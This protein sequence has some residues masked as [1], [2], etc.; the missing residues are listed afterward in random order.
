M[1]TAE[2]QYLLLEQNIF[3][4]ASR[5]P[6]CASLNQE[7]R[8]S[9][10]TL[11]TS[12]N[13]LCLLTEGTPRGTPLPAFPGNCMG[14]TK[15][16]LPGD[17]KWFVFYPRPKEWI[18]GSHAWPAGNNP[19]QMKNPADEVVSLPDFIHTQFQDFRPRCPVQGSSQPWNMIGKDLLT[20]WGEKV[21]IKP[22]GNGG[23]S[24]MSDSCIS[25]CS[26]H[27]CNIILPAGRPD[28]LT[29][30]LEGFW[31]Y[32]VPPPAFSIKTSPRF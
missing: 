12:N 2:I 22:Y 9:R 27:Q 13:W 30:G 14:I 17:P 10:I 19:S 4:P 28:Y 21:A 6:G 18:M 11:C 26:A 3:H 31:E 7:V 5:N 1:E 20:L 23:R 24:R 16:L 25:L 29:Q 15:I 32:C 8:Y